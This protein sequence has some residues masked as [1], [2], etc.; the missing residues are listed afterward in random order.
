MSLKATYISA[1]FGFSE[2]CIKKDF[3]PSSLRKPR[4]E[5]EVVR[6]LCETLCALRALRFW[7]VF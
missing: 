4:A 7:A 5:M 2:E 3:S 1:G 6:V